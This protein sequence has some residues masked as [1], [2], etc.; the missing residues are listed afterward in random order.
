MTIID[1]AVAAAL[2]GR[3]I[4]L[5]TDTV[6]GVG[7]R[8]SDDAIKLLFRLKRR[9]ADK[10]IPVLAAEVSSLAGV[11]ELSPQAMR[12]AERHW[13]GPLTLVL[14]RSRE[15]T[16]DLGGSDRGTVGVRV[17]DN[18]LTRKILGRTGPL[19]V[20]SAN[21]SGQAPALTVEE[22]RAALGGGV[23]VYVDGGKVGGEPSTVVSVGPRLEILRQGALGVE[24]L[25]G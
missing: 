13:P 16:T 22:A 1:D 10:P 7:V 6:Y 20:T 12:L 4:V 19:A 15:M 21:L 11:V 2:R 18:D 14:P 23:S 24:D 17:P 9:P 8:L 5:P 25:L 3:A